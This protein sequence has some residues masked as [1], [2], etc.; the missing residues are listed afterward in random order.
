M[1]DLYPGRTAVTIADSDGSLQSGSRF[2]AWLRSAFSIGG[3]NPLTGFAT[4][5]S[6]AF[7]GNPTVPTAAATDNDTTAANTAM[8]QSAVD[9]KLLA[10]QPHLTYSLHPVAGVHPSRPA[11]LGPV[12]FYPI[13]LDGVAA[14][15]PA[16]DGST[17]GGGGMVQYLDLWF[18][19]GA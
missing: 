10:L 1:A 9:A 2:L 6:P 11:W 14:P 5:A 18:Q 4:L 17:S 7:T 13:G 19:P 8:V 3:S 12:Q 15:K 16:L